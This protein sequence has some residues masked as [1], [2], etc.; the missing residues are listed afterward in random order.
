MTGRRDKLREQCDPF[1]FAVRALLWWWREPPGGSAM[2]ESL[3]LVEGRDVNEQTLRSVS[4]GNAKQ[5]VVGRVPEGGVVLHVAATA[6]AELGAAL[7]KFAQVPNVTQVW[8]LT[9]RTPR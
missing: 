1:L 9:L 4:L 5:L 8:T 3:I 7:L 6:P 2:I